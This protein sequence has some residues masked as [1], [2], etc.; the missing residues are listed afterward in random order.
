MNLLEHEL[1]KTMMEITFNW[2]VISFTSAKKY[3]GPV[4]KLQQIHV[5]I[6]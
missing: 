4:C 3:K 1:Q 2:R 6:K 5:L